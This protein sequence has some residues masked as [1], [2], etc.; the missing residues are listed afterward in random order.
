MCGKLFVIAQVFCV[1]AQGI[2]ECLN[3]AFDVVFKAEV[4]IG[5][6]GREDIKDIDIP[7]RRPDPVHTPHALQYA[8][9][10]PG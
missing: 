1:F 10:V 2:M 5:L 3:L 4:L 6:V 9:G 8:G 7:M